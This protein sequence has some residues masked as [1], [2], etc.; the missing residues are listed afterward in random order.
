MTNN[1]NLHGALINACFKASKSQ[2]KNGYF[3]PG[4]NGPYYHE[5]TPARNT[6]HW[7][8]V[9]CYVLKSNNL[10]KKEKKQLED[11]VSKAV[12]Y[13]LSHHSRPNMKSFFCRSSPNKDKCNGLI[14]QAWIIEGLIS[15]FNQLGIIQ[16]RNVALE[17][18]NLHPF[19]Y[20]KGVWKRVEV[21]GRILDFDYTFN[22]Q[23]WFAA[24]GTLLGDENI[25]K[26]VK[27]FLNVVGQNAE[28][29]SDG[30][31]FHATNI[32]K[33][34]LFNLGEFHNCFNS[35]WRWLQ[36]Y[37]IKKTLY[38]KSVGY[39]SFNL[40]AY[41]I[42][43]NCFPDHQF[44]ESKN[45]LRM[46]SLTYSSNFLENLDKG[47]YGWP[48]NPTGIELAYF[49]KVFCLGDVYIKNWISKQYDK[50]YDKKNDNLMT[51]GSQDVQTS[52]AR[53]YEAVRVVDNSV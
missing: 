24:V 35:I 16:A 37:R 22:H 20:D 39:H 18:F 38:I 28:I 26:K 1:F 7:I 40:Y 45:F 34:N 25:N 48:Y 10:I 19:D 13:L 53:I 36:R 33:I 5:E 27:R 14:G 8:S 46:T 3:E 4:N 41:A 12:S 44:W 43:K 49:G 32:K 51:F 2:H 50:T 6:A 52:S 15:A 31:I 23:L 42:L 21:D 29:Y 47:P 9:F 17:V 30:V 11:H